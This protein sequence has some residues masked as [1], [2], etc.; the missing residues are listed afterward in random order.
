MIQKTMIQKYVD[1]GII[2]ILKGLIIPYIKQ[3]SNA[4]FSYIRY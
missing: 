2:P 1:D 3:Y 4:I